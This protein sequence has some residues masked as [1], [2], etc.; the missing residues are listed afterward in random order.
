M[1]KYISLYILLLV[2]N[3]AFAQ[4]RR[5]ML[6][7]NFT[8]KAGYNIANISIDDNGNVDKSNQLGA[9]HV[10][11]ICDLPINKFLSFKGGLLYTGK[12]AKTEYGQPGQIGYFKATTNPMYVEMP[13]AF[14]GKIPLGLNNAP[15][16]IFGAG[17]Y[18][19]LGVSG[20]NK[21]ELQTA[22][23]IIYSNKDI[24]FDSGNT[25][26]NPIG[27]PKMKRFD[28]GLNG[29]AGV[30][31]SR[32]SLSV[33]YDLGFVKLVPGTDNNANDNGKNRVLYFS[34]GIRL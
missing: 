19:G 22:S 7:S 3:I 28:Y 16:I 14:V 21:T 13:L 24:D 2:T 26:A 6:E 9:F 12:G 20:Q 1:K 17:P 4:G 15:K 33:N 25:P 18:I 11:L 29:F 5:S 23:V 32:L 8:V 30:E 27:Y 10:G 31:F 34:V